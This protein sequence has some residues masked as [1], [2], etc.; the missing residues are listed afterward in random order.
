MKGKDPRYPQFSYDIIRLHSLMIN[1]DIIENNIVG[2]TKTPLLRCFSFISKNKSGD[3]VSTGQ[4]MNY[5]SF[6]NLQFTQ[7]LKKIFHCIK[8][9]LRDST[10][11]KI[12]F[13]SVGTT[14]LVLLFRKI[15]NNPF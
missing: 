1:S 3:I 11:E 5:Q 9:E 4:Y 15:S 14:L 10:G 7:L 2:D 6:T 8:I 13:V 12:P